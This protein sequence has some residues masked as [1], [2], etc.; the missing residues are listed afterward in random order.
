[1]KRVTSIMEMLRTL[2]FRR[3]DLP[4]SL[5][6]LFLALFGFFCPLSI[7]AAQLFGGTA[8]VLWLVSLFG[9]SA[10]RPATPAF[11]KPLIIF[12]VLSLAAVIFSTGPAASFWYSRNLLIFLIVP[13]VL[14]TVDTTDRIRTILAAAGAGAVITTTWGAVEVFLG[15]AGGD[16]GRR[17]TGFLGHYMTAGGELMVI[18]LV[19]LAV[20]LFSRGK[21]ERIAAGAVAAILLFGLILTQTRNVYVGVAA[22]A[23]VLMFIWKPGLTVLLPFV[24]SLTV[25]LSP[26]FVR[27]RIFSIGDLGDESI[28]RRLKMFDVGT[29]IIADYPL[30]G[31]GPR[32]LEEVYPHYKFDSED[33]DEVHLHNNPLQVAAER[34]IPTAIA[35]LWL[36]GALAVGHARLLSRPN[37]P[38]VLRAAAAG[39]C[40]AVTAVFTAGLFEYN[41][42]D[43]E[44]LM[45][46]LLVVTLP[47]GSRAQAETEQMDA[48]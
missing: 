17:L 40:A 44:V 21:W 32:Q 11:L 25:L 8:L 34:G 23:V 1:M 46:F 48:H 36:M 4:A 9:R 18:V 26:P 37:A 24:I 12:M 15:A 43:S 16:T 33:A 5:A 35:W 42:G 19:M 20:L 31:V 28:Q 41:F 27:E 38:P 30:F 14:F 13:V 7:A 3:D 39:A 47:F 10:V 45:L 29:S 22:G 2:G 6:F